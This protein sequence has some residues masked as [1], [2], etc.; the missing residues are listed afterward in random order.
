M[1]IASVAGDLR[2]VVEE[3]TAQILLHVHGLG[4]ER[5]AQRLAG[6]VGELVEQA[7]ALLVRQS[8]GCAANGLCHGHPLGRPPQTG[9]GCHL[10]A[11][12]REAPEHGRSH[13]C[14]RAELRPPSNVRSLHLRLLSRSRLARQPVLSLSTS[15]DNIG[16][17]PS[18]ALLAVNVGRTSFGGLSRR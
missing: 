8:T 2:R 6:R 11:F 9:I 16:P 12:H 14:G 13:D 1:T 15:A 7:L 5:R 18:S 17:S 10:L 4:L 3:D